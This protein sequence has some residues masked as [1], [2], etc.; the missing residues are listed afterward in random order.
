M[1]EKDKS[2]SESGSER[3]NSSAA[4]NLMTT[5]TFVPKPIDNIK[6]RVNKKVREYK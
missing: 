5:V 2:I 4:E 6:E 3:R 1:H